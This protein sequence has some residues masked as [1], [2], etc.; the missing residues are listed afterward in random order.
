MPKEDKYGQESEAEVEQSVFNSN[1][2]QQKSQNYYK[3]FKI[4]VED[5]K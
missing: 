1:K 3:H 5:M 4:L 2:G